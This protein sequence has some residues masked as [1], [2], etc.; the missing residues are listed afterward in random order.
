MSVSGKP[1]E[2]LAATLNWGGFPVG[3]GSSE[4]LEGALAAVRQVLGMEAAYLAEFSDGRQ[5]FRAIEGETDSFGVNVGDGLVAEGTYC[6]RM[7]DG[8]LPSVVPD[9]AADP[10][11]SDLSITRA[12][13]VG[14]YVGVPVRF[15][16]G[17]R[18]SLCCVS[19]S[20]DPDLA[21]R[22]IQFV[23]AIARLVEDHLRRLSI[24][25]Q[26]RENVDGE[27]IATTA[28]L[29]TAISRLDVASIETVLRLSRAVEFRDDDTGA[30]TARVGRYC[31]A[32]ATQAGL[33]SRFCELVLIA[34]PL[35]D[36]GKVGIPDAVLLKPGRLTTEERA[37]VEQH[38]RIGYE[39]LRNSSSD[40]L[41]LAASVAWTHH[42]KFNGSGYPRGLSGA[43]IPIEGRVTAIVD[44]HDALTSHR[45]YR[46]AFTKDQALEMMRA[47]RGSH[48]DPELLDVFLDHPPP[49]GKT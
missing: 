2:G 32:L 39:L 47:E 26:A 31:G 14:A 1:G 34:S 10:R 33:E 44:V 27:L 41:D 24:E 6:V 49:A 22:D 12:A 40:V 13:R 17:A 5:V 23:H 42:E 46:P 38:A 18:G 11:V 30:H 29:R 48:F 43:E 19:H 28:E 9:I 20:A 7:L 8:S 25:Q 3:S 35:H 45:V 37:I 21:R 36:A 4:V 16:D 15:P